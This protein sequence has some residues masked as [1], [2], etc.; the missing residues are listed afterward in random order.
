MADEKDR[1]GDKLRDKERAEEDLYFNQRDKA[2]LEKMKQQK[3]AA[4]VEPGSMR[5]PKDGTGLGAVD[6]HGVSVHECPTCGG[7]WFDKGEM[8]T[9][10]KREKDSWLGRLV[11]GPR[12]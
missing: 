6:H 3:A 10:A 7:V 12:K 2:L 4:A 8:E 9:V 11:Y 5:C 1:F